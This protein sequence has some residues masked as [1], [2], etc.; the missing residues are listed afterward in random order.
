MAIASYTTDLTI[1]TDADS[2]TG[3]SAIGGG[4]AGLN[5]EDQYFLQ[6]TNCISK[7]GWNSSAEA[8][9]VIYDSGAA[10]GVESGSAV[11]IW[12]YWQAPNALRVKSL[13]GFQ[14]LLGLDSNNYNEYYVKGSDTYT[15]GG[16][17]CLPIDPEYATA[18]GTQGTPT[19]FT[20]WDAVGV[21]C[22]Q[23][24]LVTK[25]SPIAQDITTHGRRLFVADGEAGAYGTFLSASI[26]NDAQTSRYGLFQAIDGG[27]LQQGIFCI[28]SGS[29]SCD[30]RDTARNI[31]VND[32][33]Y[34]SPSFNRFEITGSGTNVEW[35]R[36]NISALGTQAPGDFKVTHDNVTGSFDRCTFSQMGY[37]DLEENLTFDS[38]VW[39]NCDLIT[40]N[41]AS[42]TGCTFIEG[43]NVSASLLS[44]DP[45]KLSSCGFVGDGTKH[46]IEITTPGT[47]TFSGN[48]FTGYGATGTFSAS[49]YNNSG[50]EVTM[51]IT[52]FGDVATYR[53]GVGASTSIVANVAVTLTGMK[54]DTEV[55]VLAAGTNTELAGIE[56]VTDGTVDDRS[57]T[58]SLQA[59]TVVDIVVH[60]LA[61]VSI[62]IPNYEVP[63]ADTDLPIQQQVDRNYSNP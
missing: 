62:R 33:E 41:T 9:G 32:T 24:G 17:F 35:T 43:K 51:S 44:N 8:R 25:G 5:L 58:F 30:F 54:D 12:S 28:G 53:N 29:T 19:A 21:A 42:F 4:G 6:G 57:F 40:Q 45:S 18:D 38:C 48:T 23:N 11:F 31:S 3:V 61:Y 50:G 14:F 27:F 22:W 10:F 37:F 46:A 47:Y 26:V 13:G 55:R 49:L 15:Y 34:V 2:L 36:I 52:N 1:I 7:D 59:A 16:W 63:G 56:N 60:S 20:N 39:T